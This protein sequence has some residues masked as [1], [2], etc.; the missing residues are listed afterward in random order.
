MVD[1]G[2]RNVSGQPPSPLVDSTEAT[3]QTPKAT[4]NNA[5]QPT[6]PA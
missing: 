1:G 6:G 2:V 5:P 4:T 3:D